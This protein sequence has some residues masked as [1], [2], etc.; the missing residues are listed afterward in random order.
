MIGSP[1]LGLGPGTGEWSP[2]DDFDRVFDAHFAEIHR[3]VARRLDTDA[4]DDLAAETFLVAFRE[5]ERF[6]AA[7]G[8][9]RPWLYGIATNLLAR[10][11]RSEVRR[12]KALS[13]TEATGQVDSHENAVA[14]RVAA[15]QVTGRLAGA[16]A[17]L[18]KRDRDVVLLIALGGLAHAE[19]AAALGIPYGT[20]ASRLN[21]AR[22]QLRKALGDVNPLKEAGD[23]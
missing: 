22:K 19:V 2:R 5:R 14:A 3:Y 15:G 7:R 1:D 10:H 6:D 21:R 12:W 20:V 9:V 18:A 13:R 23:G 8:G 16:L 4:A 17:G 11:R